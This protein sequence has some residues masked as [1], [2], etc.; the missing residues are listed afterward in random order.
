MTRDELETKVR[1]CIIE[2]ADICLDKTTLDSKLVDDFGLDSLDLANLGMEIEEEFDINLPA[3]HSVE[4]CETVRE[5]VDV[6]E[7]AM[8]YQEVMTK[9]SVEQVAKD[10]LLNGFDSQQDYEKYGDLFPKVEP[11]SQLRDRAERAES[12]AEAAEETV[13]N[14]SKRITELEAELHKECTGGTAALLVEALKG[15]KALVADSSGIDGYHL[16]GDVAE[17]DDEAVIGFVEAT[18]AA[19]AAAKK[20]S[21]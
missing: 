7:K 2:S 10:T 15:W 1:I 18:D 13:R 11:T 6:V 16:N 4:N 3:D 19:L 20:E 12:R 9:V 14:M 5:I 8:A 17:W 21:V